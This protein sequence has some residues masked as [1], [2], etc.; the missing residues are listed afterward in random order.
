MLCVS[1]LINNLNTLYSSAQY[2][3]VCIIHDI[4]N[5]IFSVGCT[6]HFVKPHFGSIFVPSDNILILLAI[7]CSTDSAMP[8][9]Y[10]CMQCHNQASFIIIYDSYQLY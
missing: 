3:N 1:V 9:R 6:E 8:N 10:K 7:T 5:K 2:P 4:T